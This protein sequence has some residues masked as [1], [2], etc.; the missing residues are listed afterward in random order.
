MQFLN[1]A[2]RGLM[3]ICIVVGLALAA[4]FAAKVAPQLMDKKNLAGWS[5]TSIIM[6][7]CW[8]PATLSLWF[9]KGGN[10]ALFYV[11]ALIAAV[12]TG[13]SLLIIGFLSSFS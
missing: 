12:V 13:Y 8:L 6:A 3:W 5:M 10:I 4:W 2:I 9:G 7:F 1:T 11:F